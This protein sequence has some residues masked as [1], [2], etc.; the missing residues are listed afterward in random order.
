MNNGQISRVGLTAILLLAPLLGGATQHWSQSLII[1]LIAVLILLFP[2]KRVDLSVGIAGGGLLFLSALGFL[3]WRWFGMPNWRTAVAQSGI[4]L[5][6]TLSPQPWLTL[7]AVLL[8]I[9]GLLW[10][11]WLTAQPWSADQRRGLAKVFCIGALFLGIVAVVAYYGDLSIPLWLRSERR[12]GPFPNRNQTGNFFAI[13]AILTL[14][15]AYEELRRHRRKQAACWFGFGLFLFGVLVLSYSRAGV[16]IFFLGVLIWI[17][18]LSRS[19]K[20]IALGLVFILFLLTGFILFGGET[21]ERFRSHAGGEFRV[22]VWRD[23]WAMLASSKWMGVGLG[24]FDSLFPFFRHASVQE[25]R[26][27]HPESDWLWLA[28]EAGVPS[29]IL[30]LAAILF[31]L[32]RVFPLQ[33]N[34]ARSLRIACAICVLMFM[35]HGFLDVS[36]H[37]FG[38]VLPAI[39]VLALSLNSPEAKRIPPPFIP[40]LFRLAGLLLLL[41]AGWRVWGS[42]DE[43]A[44]AAASVG[45]KDYQKAVSHYTLALQSAPLDWET[46]YLRGATEVAMHQWLDA[47]GDFRRANLLEPQLQKVPVEEGALWLAYN[48]PLAIQAWQEALDRCRPEERAALFSGL[49]KTSVGSRAVIDR[50]SAIAEG[51]IDLELAYLSFADPEKC[52]ELIS[53]LRPQAEKLRKDQKQILFFATARLQAGQ[54]DFEA[55]FNTARNVINLPVLPKIQELPLEIAQRDF[56]KDPGNFAAAYAL[57]LAQMKAERLSDALFTLDKVRQQK[58]APAYFGFLAAE[59]NARRGNWQEAWNRLQPFLKP[60]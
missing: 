47:L 53:K 39:F 9:A 32:R 34:T 3:P 55:A 31:L 6:E 30:T 26:I 35:L 17:S 42:P 44:V 18:A 60:L 27:L 11:S 5:P 38:T 1:S 25:V 10:L 59:L 7:D 29:V 54:N 19:G 21:L 14:A 24:N 41:A 46:Y 57:Y 20:K 45:K 36:G 2:P 40:W 28:C 37:R 43:R 22:L 56:L 58:D 4:R 23:A 8:L 13:S 52:S 15:L 51:N 50:M 12:F 48:P 33:P 49:L 16:G